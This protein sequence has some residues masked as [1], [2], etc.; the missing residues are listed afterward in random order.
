[1]KPSSITRHAATM[2]RIAPF[3]REFVSTGAALISF[4]ELII[5]LHK[6][7]L[8]FEAVSLRGQAPPLPTALISANVPISAMRYD[9]WNFSCP[10]RKVH[11]RVGEAFHF[12]RKIVP[13][14][15]GIEKIVRKVSR[16]FLSD[17]NQT[18]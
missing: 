13:L 8:D 16:A 10:L 7:K 12:C 17:V 4:P 5:S 2:K 15:V 1:M 11:L 18:T 9:E 3:S 6:T 14:P